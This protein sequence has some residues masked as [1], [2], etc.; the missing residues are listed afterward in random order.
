MKGNYFYLLVTIF[1]SHS[2]IPVTI[3]LTRGLYFVSESAGSVVICYEILSGRTAS[4]RI[5]MEFRT[6][7]G[8]AEG[9]QNKNIFTHNCIH[10][11]YVVYTNRLHIPSLVFI[12][13][14]CHFSLHILQ[15]VGTTHTHILQIQLTTMTHLTVVEF[16]FFQTV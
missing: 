11:Y 1:M 10:D 9:I 6:V 13:N 3:G 12:D 15:M 4:R 14:L 16:P 8:E 7:Q 2:A 5:S